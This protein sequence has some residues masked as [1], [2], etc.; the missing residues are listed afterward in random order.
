MPRWLLVAVLAPLL[1][2]AVI[3]GLNVYY[4][5]NELRGS[6]A[7]LKK[8]LSN[9]ASKAEVQARFKF[10]AYRINKLDERIEANSGRIQKNRDA[11]TRQQRRDAAALFRPPLP[12]DQ[13]R[14]AATAYACAR[15]AG[16]VLMT[17]Q[18]GTDAAAKN[19][20]FAC[21]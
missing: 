21:Q 16:P 8:V 20:I 1:V 19:L 4:G 17:A 2:T 6:V 18:A 3:N 14:S 5:Q 9:L 15:P 10:F 13:A 11:I 7:E 12:W